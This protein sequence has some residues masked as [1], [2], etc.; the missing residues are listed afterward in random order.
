MLIV[1][2][3]NELRFSFP[4]FASIFN[5]AILVIFPI[6]SLFFK[7]CNIMNS[8]Y[9]PFSLYN[10]FELIHH[11]FNR[12][13]AIETNTF[14]EIDLTKHCSLCNNRSSQTYQMQTFYNKNHLSLDEW[15]NYRGFKIVKTCG[16]CHNQEKKSYTFSTLQTC[17]SCVKCGTVSP[18]TYVRIT[19]IIFKMHFPILKYGRFECEPCNNSWTSNCIFWGYKHQCKKCLKLH[20]PLDVS[21]EFFNLINFKEYQF[22]NVDNMEKN[23]LSKLCEKCA[24]KGGQCYKLSIVEIEEIG[25]KLKS[26][27]RKYMD[28]IIQLQES[29]KK[30]LHDFVNANDLKNKKVSIELEL[31]KERI[32]QNKVLLK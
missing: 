10:H 28:P 7:N 25:I 5:I 1:L 21:V 30:E 24:V 12:D 3:S 2:S 4:K 13:C 8:E 19:D 23:H 32:I 18:L 11:C 6:N 14:L 27:K 9:K 22:P 15:E 20:Y 29:K 16:Q 17:K 26:V 31:E